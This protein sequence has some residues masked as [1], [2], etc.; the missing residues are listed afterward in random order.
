ME[1]LASNTLCDLIKTFIE[2]HKGFDI[3]CIS[4]E[5]RSPI[6]D[7]MIIASGTS[8]R[9]IQMMGELLKEHL[10]QHGIKPIFIEGAPACD[11]VLL[12]AGDVIVHFFR[13]E[14]REFYNLEKMWGVEL[15]DFSRKATGSP[16]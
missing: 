8:H 11:W 13:P 7:F 10:H 12:D 2:D 9:H 16:L 4:L 6:A 14:A 1:P 5:N 3:T 15:A